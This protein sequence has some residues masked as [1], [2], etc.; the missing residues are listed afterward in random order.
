MAEIVQK[1]RDDR[2]LRPV[3]IE[4]LPD[5]G[6]LALDNADQGAGGVEDTDRMRE[7]RVGRTRE[8]ELGNA[9]LLDATQP[10][11]LGRIEQ[12]P[13]ELVQL[14]APAKRDEPWTG[15]RRRWSRSF[16]QRT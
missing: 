1:R 6:D 12:P 5:P 3:R 4:R 2:D 15:S 11:E 9:E 10:L 7:A 8:Y 14:D 16:M 13:G